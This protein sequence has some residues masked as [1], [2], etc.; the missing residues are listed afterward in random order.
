MI[1][2]GWLTL[3][4]GT[5]MPDLLPRFRA[6]RPDDAHAVAGLHTDSWQRHYRGA[7]SDAFLDGEV[8]EY[9]ARM[10][11]ERLATPGPQARTIVAEYDGEVVGIAHTLLGED[12]RWGALIDNLHVRYALKRQGSGPG[13]WP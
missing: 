10:W 6:A 9:L 5:T 8:S 13:C 1:V 7:Y 4:R 2:E 3:P 11:T 12:P